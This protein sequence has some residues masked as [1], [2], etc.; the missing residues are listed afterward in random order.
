MWN[1]THST[2]SITEVRLTNVHQRNAS[3]Y[4]LYCCAS[5]KVSECKQGKSIG[6][7]LLCNLLLNIFNRTRPL[8]SSGMSW[9]VSDKVN[10][11]FVRNKLRSKLFSIAIDM[12][13]NLL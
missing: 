5:S 8:F 7:C 2:K 4:F 12:Q 1:S 3:S 13:S 6:D 11:S 9:N 10:L